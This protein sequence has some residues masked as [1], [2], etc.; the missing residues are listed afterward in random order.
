MLWP[1]LVM[2]PASIRDSPLLQGLVISGHT[3]HTYTHCTHRL[4]PMR[5]TPTYDS[6]ED[7]PREGDH[8]VCNG[9]E[10]CSSSNDQVS[11]L[12][13][14]RHFVPTELP[15]C[16]VMYIPKTQA[17]PSYYYCSD[18]GAMGLHGEIIRGGSPNFVNVVMRGCVQQQ[19]VNQVFELYPCQQQGLSAIYPYHGWSNLRIPGMWNETLSYVHTPFHPTDKEVM[20]SDSSK[21]VVLD[22]L[23]A[24][25]KAGGHRVLIYS[26][27][28]RMI[29][30]LEVGVVWGGAMMSYEVT[31]EYMQYRH[32]RYIRLDGSS[33]I[34]E[35]RDMVDDFQ[36]K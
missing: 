27:M 31:Q 18:T 19:Q 35:R 14:E 7:E 21:M 36:T 3:H 6:C 32:H 33:R 28:T 5:T 2:S 26:Q 9:L 29:D 16:L 8:L 10:Y 23:L 15:R 1:D 24:K 11:T 17:T 30:I 12:Y 4:Y 25:L 34:S 22:R 13:T 20:I